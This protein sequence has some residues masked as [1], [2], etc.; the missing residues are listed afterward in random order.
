MD[1]AEDAWTKA[2]KLAPDDRGLKS[3]LA[4]VKNKK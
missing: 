1:K 4:K 3:F 2:L